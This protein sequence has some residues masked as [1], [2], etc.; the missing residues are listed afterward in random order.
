MRPQIEIGAV[1]YSHQLVPLPLLLLALGEETILNVYRAL[2]VV[3]QLL[4]WLFIQTQIVCR[5]AETGEPV[6]AGINPFLMRPLVFAGTDEV[7]H[8]H[9]LEL[10]RAENEVAGSDFVAKRFAN[11]RDAERKFAPAGRQHVEKINEDALRRL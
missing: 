3:G 4:F 9:L 8:L 6:V 11:L 5:D 7:F 1:G 10:A 2:G